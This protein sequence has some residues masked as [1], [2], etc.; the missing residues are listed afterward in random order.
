MLATY[1]NG[2]QAKCLKLGLSIPVFVQF[3]RTNNRIL[4]RGGVGN[5][6]EE[7]AILTDFVRIKLLS[8]PIWGS[9]LRDQSFNGDP[10]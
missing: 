7:I 8:S 6:K 5:V 4:L 3:D 1:S 9:R 10:S 2:D